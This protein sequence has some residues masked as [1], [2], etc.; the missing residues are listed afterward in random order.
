MD[1]REPPPNRKS[2]TDLVGSSEATQASKHLPT[3]SFVAMCQKSLISAAS[4]MA[5]GVMKK[6]EQKGVASHTKLTQPPTTRCAFF[7]CVCVCF[8]CFSGL[9]NPNLCFFA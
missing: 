4:W 3:Q 1:R 6:I 7:F 2:A 8:F 5:G 9:G